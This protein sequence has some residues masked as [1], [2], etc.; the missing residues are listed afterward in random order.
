MRIDSYPG[1]KAIVL[2]LS[3]VSAGGVNTF[4]RAASF[5]SSTAIPVE[6]THTIEAGKAKP[7]DAVIAKT[8]EIVTL[9]GGTIVPKGATLVGHVVES[10]AFVFDPT[11]Y[12]IQKPSTL[13]IHFD[14]VLAR[15]EMIRVDM[16][17][18]ALANSGTAYEAA[19]PQ[20]IDESD[21]LGTM[22][23]VGGDH[24]SPISKEVFSSDD[25]DIVGYNRKDGVFARLIA[26]DYVDRYASVRCDSTSTE[27]S[28]GIFSASACGLYGFYQ[29][30]MSEDG[31]DDGGS[32]KLE[33]RHRNVKL[34]AHSA[35][36][37][38]VLE[39]KSEDALNA[40]TK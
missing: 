1:S 21:H 23:Q 20:G 25:E 31:S 2:L 12:A 33:S 39:S 19:V 3:I 11:P 24:F 13:S 17:V 38:Q 7:G 32:F 8:I 30:Y 4:C 16:S 5:P 6:F 34:Y 36:L 40:S 28:V 18:R 9:S 22:V 15:N 14:K 37:L 29:V 27:Q 35:A 10:R 26:N